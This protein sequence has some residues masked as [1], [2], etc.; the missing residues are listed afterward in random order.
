MKKYIIKFDSATSGVA[1]EKHM[2]VYIR[3]NYSD[4]VVAESAIEKV[5]WDLTSQVEMYLATHKTAKSVE[6]RKSANTLAGGYWITV[7]SMSLNL[8]PV[9]REIV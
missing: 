8:K 9:R 4:A 3:D 7:G 1:V 2:Q 6:V 5:L